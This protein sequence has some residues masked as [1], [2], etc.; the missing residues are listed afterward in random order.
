MIVPH[1]KQVVFRI[2]RNLKRGSGRGGKKIKHKK[3]KRNRKSQSLES[4]L[5]FKGY[6]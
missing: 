3:K 6:K 1:M 5:M 4:R 2:L